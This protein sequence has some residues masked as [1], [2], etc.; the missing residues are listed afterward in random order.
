MPVRSSRFAAVGFWVTALAGLPVMAVSWMWLSL[1]SLEEVQEAAKAGSGSDAADGTTFSYGGI[2]LVAAHVAGLVL[3]SIFGSR[4]RFRPVPASI[5]A[6]VIVAIESAFGF[7]VTFA[8]NGGQIFTPAD[9]GY[10]P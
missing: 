6:F 1:M 3:I 7:F 9:G 2:P 5:L 4:W 10:T 8:V